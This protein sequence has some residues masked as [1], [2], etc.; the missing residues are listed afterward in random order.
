MTNTTTFT[1]L[2][3]GDVEVWTNGNLTISSLS[4]KPSSISSK[5]LTHSSS[6]ASTLLVNVW[7]DQIENHAT[8]LFSFS[9]G[10]VSFHLCR[11]NSI[12]LTST[13][14]ILVS[15]TASLDMNQVW[16]SHVTSST[17]TSGSC[18]DA[19]T[20]SS[21]TIISSDAA[22]CSSSG[23]AGVFHFT[24]LDN[25]PLTL[26]D[27]V[28]TSNLASSSHA[29]HGND[30][31]LVNYPPKFLSVTS[32]VK[33]ISQKP[34]VLIDGDEVEIQIPDYGYHSYG[35]NHPLNH[36]FY[37]AVPMSQFPGIKLTIQDLVSPGSLAC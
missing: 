1:I 29:K 31:V 21:I 25:N 36:G 12:T 10:Q 5:L 32:S 7:V 6:D 8:H 30:I 37:L 13:S 20:S 18:V 19:R 15:G 2:K 24:R 26:T 22:H 11:F 23:P 14:A 9:E 28:F 33:S 16:F 35:I 34:R 4:L 27:I 17:T 3:M